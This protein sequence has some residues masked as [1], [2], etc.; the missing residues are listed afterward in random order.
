VRQD[1][2][3]DEPPATPSW[4]SVWGFGGTGATTPQPAGP[5]DD[6]QDTR[7][8]DDQDSDGEEKR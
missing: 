1:E 3:D 2:A 4:R 7:P 5:D 8:V 6:P